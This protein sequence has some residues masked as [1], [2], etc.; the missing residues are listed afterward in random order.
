MITVLQTQSSAPYIFDVTV[1]DDA[2]RTRHQVTMDQAMY[3]RL[4]G[5][6][7][8]P[9][10]CIEETFAFLLE[11]E[12]K[13]ALLPNFDLIFVSAFF[14]EFISEFKNRLASARPADPP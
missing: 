2:G 10:R 9:A 7:I 6:R 5:G 11:R 12:T 3:Q 4:T 13:E 14:P 1:E 8:P